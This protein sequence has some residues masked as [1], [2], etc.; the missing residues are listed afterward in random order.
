MKTVVAVATLCVA[1][2][3]WIKT[4]QKPVDESKIACYG[5]QFQSGNDCV[6][7]ALLKKGPLI[8]DWNCYCGTQDLKSE[9]VDVLALAD[10]TAQ[11]GYTCQCFIDRNA[12]K[13]VWDAYRK[14]CVSV[15]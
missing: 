10:P 15:E 2:N 11:N 5:L 13:T 6:C 7:P 9:I 4:Y 1:A 3:S 12:K 14:E 8:G